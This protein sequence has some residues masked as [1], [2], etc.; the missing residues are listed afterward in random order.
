MQRDREVIKADACGNAAG[1]LKLTH[2]QLQ[3][4]RLAAAVASGEAEPPAG[5][6]LKAHV[7]EHLF[8]AAIV[9]KAE[10]LYINKRHICPSLYI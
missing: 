10:I 6:Y 4:R 3:K 1:I 7:V 2:Q 5:V 8:G 9:C